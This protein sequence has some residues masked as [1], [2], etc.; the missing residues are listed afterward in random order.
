MAVN[1]QSTN[2]GT[3]VTQVLP[4]PVTSAIIQNTSVTST[5]YF[6]NTVVS[7][8][9]YG[10]YLTPG[11][12]MHLPNFNQNEQLYAVGSGSDATLNILYTR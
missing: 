3:V 6:G 1:Q 7:A 9:V 12:T 10:F 11:Q 2:I 4:Y 8:S 5:I